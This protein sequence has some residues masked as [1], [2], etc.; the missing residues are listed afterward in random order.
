MTNL[1]NKIREQK[2]AVSGVSA[3]IFNQSLTSIFEENLVR[4]RGMLKD[5][6]DKNDPDNYGAC[7]AIGGFNQ[8]I[9]AE[10]AYYEELIKELKK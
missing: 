9:N 7:Y 5:Q 4:L 1:L 10:I 6:L 2:E 3:D 8:A